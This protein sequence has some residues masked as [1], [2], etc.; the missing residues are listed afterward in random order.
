MLNK[1][2][3]RFEVKLRREDDAADPKIVY[4]LQPCKQKLFSKHPHLQ[5]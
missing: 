3:M 4:S 1:I 2:N 5:Q